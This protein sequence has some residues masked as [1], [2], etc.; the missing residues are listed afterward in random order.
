MRLHFLPSAHF[1]YGYQQRAQSTRE[2]KL[3]LAR[4]GYVAKGGRADLVFFGNLERAMLRYPVIRAFPTRATV[5]LVGPRYLH[6]RSRSGRPDMASEILSVTDG[7]HAA[8]V[9][10][11][12][13]TY[14]REVARTPD[15]VNTTIK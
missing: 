4:R 6:I 11:M 2:K 10:E 14:A 7:E 3:R 9:E 5:N 13:T 12:E 15:R 8:I 1:R